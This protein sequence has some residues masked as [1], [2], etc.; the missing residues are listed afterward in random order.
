MKKKT[1]ITLLSILFVSLFLTISSSFAANEI[2][3]ATQ[4]IRNVV[5]GA[6]NMMQ[7]AAGGIVNGVTNGINGSRNTAENMMNTDNNTDNNDRATG[8]T[9]SGRENG[10]YTATRTAT[11]ANGGNDTFLGMGPTAWTWMIFA[12]LG[13]ITVALVWYYGKQHEYRSNHNDF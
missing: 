3:G 5:G 13:I 2:A 6:E 7:D 11:T 1:F 10:N 8:T 9:T 4:G 12:G